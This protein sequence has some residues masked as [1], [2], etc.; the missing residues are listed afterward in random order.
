MQIKQGS[1]SPGQNRSTHHD[2]VSNATRSSST[3]AMLIAQQSANRMN[4]MRAPNE[5]VAGA[6]LTE[7]VL[8]PR[9][10]FGSGQ[11]QTRPLRSMVSSVSTAAQ[12]TSSHGRHCTCVAIPNGNTKVCTSRDAGSQTNP[13]NLG[14]PTDTCSCSDIS[15][16]PYRAYCIDTRTGLAI[17]ADRRAESGEAGYNTHAP[18][19]PS[20]NGNGRPLNNPPPR[21]IRRPNHPGRQLAPYRREKFTID[22]V[23]EIGFVIGQDDHRTAASEGRDTCDTSV[24]QC[25]DGRIRVV[26]AR[27]NGR[28]KR[29]TVNHYHGHPRS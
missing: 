17:P 26:H 12:N 9:P 29:V 10:Q 19:L 11:G 5:K 23:D 2:Y 22:K 27:G 13:R 1:S 6:Q 21:V 3:S 14:L 20:T 8:Q 24:W 25:E 7:A 4:G 28:E 16:N 15:R 18:A